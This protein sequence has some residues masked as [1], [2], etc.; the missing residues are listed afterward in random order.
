VGRCGYH[1]PCETRGGYGEE[2]VEDCGAMRCEEVDGN[3][4][5]GVAARETEGAVGV[6]D[7]VLVK[8][9]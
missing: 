1:G 6:L 2:G 8:R 9:G 3:W 4:D 5:C 7:V